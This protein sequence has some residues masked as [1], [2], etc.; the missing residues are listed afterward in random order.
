MRRGL[1]FEI[2]TL[3]NSIIEAASGTIFETEIVQ[4]HDINFLRRQTRGWSFRWPMELLQPDR[5]I[6]ALVKKVEPANWQGLVR[7]F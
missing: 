7:F 3:T 6:V 2:D 1:D 5:E 4:V